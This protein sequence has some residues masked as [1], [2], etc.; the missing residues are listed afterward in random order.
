MISKDFRRAC[1]ILD[2]LQGLEKNSSQD[3]IVSVPRYAFGPFVVAH[4]GRVLLRDGELVK[5]SPKVLATLMALLSGSGQ[6][7]TKAALLNAIWPDSFTEEASLAQNIS[8]LRKLLA[9][10]YP[11]RSPIETIPRVGYRFAGHLEIEDEHKPDLGP[12]GI[13]VLASGVEVEKKAGFR[14]WSLRSWLVNLSS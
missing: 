9:P 11:D 10:S 7:V 8:V 4:S 2:A 14:P 13:A 1:G 5:I 6:V 3:T 12:E